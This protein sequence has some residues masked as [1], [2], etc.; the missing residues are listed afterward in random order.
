MKKWVIIL[1]AAILLS[2]C[3]NAEETEDETKKLQ[4]RKMDVTVN[5]N[6]VLLTGE[7]Q[8]AAQKIYFTLEQG[9]TT[10]VEETSI[11]L[12]KNSQGWSE[13]N[14]DM[15]I[16]KKVKNAEEVPI[17]ILYGKTENGKMVNKNHIPVDLSSSEK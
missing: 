10:L 1:F 4:F 9:D 17:I 2:A 8:T 3:S 5:E 11:K 7:A 15:E 12:Q 13:F 6:T 14:I 16:N